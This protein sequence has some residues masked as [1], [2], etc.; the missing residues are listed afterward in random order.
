MLPSKDPVTV[1]LILKSNDSPVLTTRMHA[2]GDRHRATVVP[3]PPRSGPSALRLTVRYENG[4]VD[5]TADD[6]TFSVGA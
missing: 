5:A 2:E 4:T 1:D 6:R 3:M